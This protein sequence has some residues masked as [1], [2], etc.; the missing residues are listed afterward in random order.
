MGG[1]EILISSGGGW[2]RYVVA[3][4]LVGFLLMVASGS[5]T[6]F[7]RRYRRWLG[8]A[9]GLL[10][11][12][13]GVY[14]VYGAFGPFWAAVQTRTTGG[15]PSALLWLL[16]GLVAVFVGLFFAIESDRW[17]IER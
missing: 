17:N 11:M 8:L 7:L 9:L 13:L 15:D 1:W 6:P 14:W 12:G 4:V 3:S 5:F 10:L 16:G 2:V